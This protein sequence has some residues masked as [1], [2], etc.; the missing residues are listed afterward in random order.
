MDETTIR[1][2]R[3]LLREPR[4]ED[5]EAYAE[6]LADEDAA[7]WIG[8]M[9]PRAAAW[10]KFLQQP[11]AWKVQGFGMFSVIDP[12]TGDWLGQLGP[13]RPDGWPG[14]EIGYAF[15][16]RAWGNGY[17]TE[18]AVAAIDWAFAHLGWDDIVHCIHPDNLPSKRVAARLG[19]T[20]LRTGA[21]LP[22]PSE[23]VDV[24]LWGQ[25]RAQWQVN[26]TRFA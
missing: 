7:R 13:W 5:F 4:L 20:V 8:G 15:H 14:N 25:T 23:G 2:A 26:R 24:E 17:A 9:Q 1:T 18:A 11:G 19:S 16:P 21:L 10:R 3:L 12:A 22:A 6:L